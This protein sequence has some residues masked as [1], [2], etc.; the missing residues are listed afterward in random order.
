M[1]RHIN[2]IMV[3]VLGFVL[4]ACSGRMVQ[5]PTEDAKSKKVPVRHVRVALSRRF[6]EVEV[7]YSVLPQEITARK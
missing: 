6:L 3:L 4:S 5:L 2:I 1:K 7:V